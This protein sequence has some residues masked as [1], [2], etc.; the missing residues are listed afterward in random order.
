MPCRG[1]VSF[2]GAADM[3]RHT[4]FDTDKKPLSF[5]LREIHNLI[6]T[7]LHK[8]RPPCPRPGTPPTQL[9]GGI[10]GYLYH[11]DAAEPVYQKNIEEVF[12]ISRATATNTLQV[13]EKN[14]LITRRAE[15]QDGRLKRIFMTEEAYREHTQ[16]EKQMER[17]DEAMLDGMSSAEVEQFLSLL[18]R[19]RDN[20]ERMDRESGE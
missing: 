13:M 14:G 2:W 4:G 3:G 15:D 5:E 18:D 1:A 10:M 8:M 7:L 17:L 9:Q 11:H 19:V 16:I 12:R 6:K 20:L